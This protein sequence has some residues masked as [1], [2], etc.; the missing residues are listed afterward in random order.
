MQQWM[1]ENGGRERGKEGRRGKPTTNQPSLAP[2]GGNSG[3][4]AGEQTHERKCKSREQASRGRKGG[5]KEGCV[6]C[7]PLYEAKMG[8]KE[9]GGEKDRQKLRQTQEV[10]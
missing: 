10:P 4:E 2:E 5:W 6:V 9:K 7:A 8:G 3:R 1:A